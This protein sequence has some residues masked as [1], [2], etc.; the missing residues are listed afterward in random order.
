MKLSLQLQTQDMI[1][2][3]NKNMQD[4]SDMTD[5]GIMTYFLGMEVDQSDQG[6]FISQHAF[7]LKI[8]TKFHMENCKPVSTPLVRG[9]KLS[10]Y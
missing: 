8:L 10:S 5:L 9:Q 7:A 4:M 2:E 3:F 1:Q 6:I